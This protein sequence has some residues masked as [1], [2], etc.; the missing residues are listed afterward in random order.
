MKNSVLLAFL[1]VF[2]FTLMLFSLF[3]TTFSQTPQL[4]D[5]LS[6]PQF[7]NQLN[8]PPSVFV[9]TNVTDK[10]GNL[11]RQ[12]YTVKVSQFTQQILPTI[13]AAGQPTGF[14]PTKV[15]GYEGQAKNAVTGE[16]MGD[17]SSTPGSTFE[18]IQG[19]PIQV[20]WVNN[21]VDSQGKP[22]S[23]FVPVDPTIHWA[24]P[25]NLPMDMTNTNTPSFP[26]GNLEAQSSVPIVTHLHGGEVQSTSDG[27]PNAWWTADGKHGPDYNTAVPTDPNAAVD[28]YPNAQQPT[29]LWYHDHALGLTRLNV[30][31]GL[32]GF[33]LIT[34]SSDPVQQLLPQGEF[35]VPL[36]VQDRSF[37]SDGSLYYP[38]EGV[39]P[40]IH[41]YWQNSFLGNTIIVNGE[42]WPN[43]NVKQGL[44]RFRIL[45][46]SNSRFYSI[47]FSNGV[48]FTQ[49]GT[50]GGYLK[51]PV[52]LTS[53][54]IAPG[55]RID[56][57]VD[58][59][60]VQAGQ[61][62]ILENFA[63]V[64]SSEQEAQTTGRIMQFTVTD[65]KGFTPQTLPSNLNPTLSGD[66]PTLPST[67]KQRI[68]TLTDVQG[69]NGPT[70]TLLDGQTWSAPVSEKPTLGS[71]ED[72]VLVNPTMDV[73][74]IH[75]H[76]V[77]FQIVK[78]QSI[79]STAYINAWKSLNGDPPLNHPTKNVP[80]LEPFF[81]GTS[82]GPTSSEEGWKDTVLVNP[83][84][85]VTIR[86]RWAEQDGNP[87]P[88]DATV[89]PGYVW[90]CHLL[91]HE[92]NEMMRPYIVVSSNQSLNAGITFTV[93]IAAV[94]IAVLIALLF[95]KRFRNRAKNSFASST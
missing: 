37:Y 11:I 67:S 74:P 81:T 18:A 89:G 68:L 86:I 92:D 94:I 88:F 70:T 58:F 66:F 83:G 31:S 44:Y 8:Q 50:D 9:P 36:A 17:V 23:Y 15:W 87:Y 64:S 82:S 75:V 60:H 34:N 16:A 91:E 35:E 30:L 5:P 79:D 76:L 14:A 25:N 84:E 53:K 47:S 49:I 26:P 19:V 7:V 32:A 28:V 65:N 29:T 48:G 10:S 61:K 59:S 13:N 4:L 71:T 6:I 42:A 93:I 46:G 1:T 52:Q 43:M 72:W 54:I 57:L 40:T 41:P 55:E 45:D 80:S 24:N 21:L 20:K 39:N 56:I 95:Q 12:E 3:P 38:T 63:G 27:G 73:H 90:H 51:A 78:H 33:Y 2:C 22:L 77:Q 85:M 62:I 69:A